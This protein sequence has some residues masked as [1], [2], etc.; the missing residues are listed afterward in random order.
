[1]TSRFYDSWLSRKHLVQYL[2]Q[3]SANINQRSMDGGRDTELA[4]GMYQPSYL[5]HNSPEHTARGQVC[6]LSSRLQSSTII[7]VDS[8]LFKPAGSIQWGFQS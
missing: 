3:G 2:I 4:M 8:M 5:A 1:M 7:A 6:P